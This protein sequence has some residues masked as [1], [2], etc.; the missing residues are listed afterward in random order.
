M[1]GKRKSWSTG[2]AREELRQQNTHQKDQMERNIFGRGGEAMDQTEKIRILYTNTQ[3]LFSKINELSA[4]TSILKPDVVMLTETWTNG[5]ISDAMIQLPGYR[6]EG[7]EDRRDTHNGIGGGLAFYI[8]DSIEILSISPELGDFNQYS[9]ISINTR[10]GPLNLLLIYRPP[11]SNKENFNQLLHLLQFT[12]KNTI[13]MGD[14]NMPGIDWDTEQATG[15]GRVMLDVI[16][17]AGLEQLIRFP[18]HKK[19]NTLDLLISDCPDK[20]ISIEDAGCLGNSDHCM[21]VTDVEVKMSKTV[22]VPKINWR[23]GDFAAIRDELECTDW[24]FLTSCSDLNEAWNMFK[25]RL[26]ALVDTFVPRKIMKGAGQP[27][28]LTREIKTQINQKRKAWK[29]LRQEGGATNRDLYDRA[30]KKLKRV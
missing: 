12:S 16:A 17:A 20:I 13:I 3:S 26:T 23:K 18:T 4:V 30:N 1:V 11:S 28:W 27:K 22:P 8:K 25:N 9:S 6:L 19:G 7:R 21:I 29:R 10:N 5:S 15:Q 14:F 24:N 2:H